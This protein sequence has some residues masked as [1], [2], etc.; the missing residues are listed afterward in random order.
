MKPKYIPILNT[1]ASRKTALAA[2]VAGRS[3]VPVVMAQ[4]RL[5]ALVV[6]VVVR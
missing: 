6:V 1:F 4:E 3:I 5:H 2:M